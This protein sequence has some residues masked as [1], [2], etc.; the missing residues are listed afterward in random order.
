MMDGMIS[1]GPHENETIALFSQHIRNLETN[2]NQTTTIFTYSL[3]Q[4]AD[5]M[6]TKR[7]RHGIQT[8][9]D[10]FADD[11]I[12]AM[13][14]YYKL[15]ASGL[16]QGGNKDW[17]AWVEPYKFVLGGKMGTTEAAPV[18]DMSIIL[19]LFLGVAVVDMYLDDYQHSLSGNVSSSFL[20]SLYFYQQCTVH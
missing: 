18:Y 11:L 17:V 8:P 19:P 12:T 15:F 7:L 13:S 10:D 9:V 2:C 3:G 4:E 1:T 16:G 14:S 20:K 5:Y 6:V